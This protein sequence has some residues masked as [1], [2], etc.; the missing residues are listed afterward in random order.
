MIFNDDRVF[1][2]LGF[3]QK[4][5]KVFSG[6][7]TVEAKISKR[8]ASLVIVASDAPENTKR[9]MKRLADQ[10]RIPIKI[11]GEKCELGIAIGKSPRNV[12]LIMDAG[13]AGTLMKYLKF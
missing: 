12:V 5:G 8:G 10:K 6:D 7:A 2:M 13:F 4:A 9:K 1:T 3:A 11:F